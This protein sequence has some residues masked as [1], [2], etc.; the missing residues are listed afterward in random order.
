MT[1]TTG[2]ADIAWPFTHSST[3]WD[4]VAKDLEEQGGMA[5]V[6]LPCKSGEI[7]AHAFQVARRVLDS[8]PSHCNCPTIPPNADS[9]HVTGYHST[10]GMSRYNAFREGL[11]FSNGEMVGDDN[12]QYAMNKM[13]DSLHDI[14][15]CVLQAMERRW[16]LPHDWFQMELGPTERHS[17]WHI[18]RYIDL[19]ADEHTKNDN[20]ESAIW[21]PVHTDPS[22][23]SVVVHDAVGTSK[24]AMGLEYQTETGEWMEIPQSGHLSATIFV[25]SVLS[26]M[27]GGRTRAAKHRVMY[28]SKENHGKRMAST[29]FV[30][31][32]G[33]ARLVVPPSPRF[34]DVV[35]KKQ[36]TFDA[37]SSRVSRN[38]MK[39]KKK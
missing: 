23:I 17:Q 34:E 30:R 9:A 5:V 11:V 25:G 1:T 4:D 29:L 35:L 2:T 24:G 13:L 20:D 7:H 21:L 33:T 31:P 28:S 39:H 14:A 15:Q 18:K 19:S 10:E 22:L 36:T 27:T 37:W 16:N 12:V 26:Y 6:A 8:L 32:R 3:T 38:Y